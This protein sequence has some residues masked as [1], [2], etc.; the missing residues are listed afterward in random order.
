MMNWLPIVRGFRD[1]L[2][3]ALA[4]AKPTGGLDGLAALAGRRLFFLETIQLDR[5][6]A[7]LAG[8]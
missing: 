7:R 8:R 4:R 1:D 6:L 2:R 3:A 5:A